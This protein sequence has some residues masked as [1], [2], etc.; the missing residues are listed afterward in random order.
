MGELNENAEPAGSVRISASG[1][2]AP[3]K[4]DFDRSSAIVNNRFLG[5]CALEAGGVDLSS[6]GTV[7][8]SRTGKHR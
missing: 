4:K 2:E 3:L 5:V 6:I 1:I 7:Q 8:K